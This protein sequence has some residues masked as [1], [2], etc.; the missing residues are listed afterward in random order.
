MTKSMSHKAG[1]CYRPRLTTTS[2]TVSIEN[3]EGTNPESQP[4]LYI[5]TCRYLLVLRGSA[6][7]EP[8][9]N[10]VNIDKSQ[11]SHLAMQMQRILKYSSEIPPC[12]SISFATRVTIPQAFAPGSGCA[13]VHMPPVCT[14]R[15]AKMVSPSD[16]EYTCPPARQHPRFLRGTPASTDIVGIDP[17]WTADG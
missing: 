2:L 10:P 5:S 17:P 6:H 3:W 11:S 12:R 13:S 7:Q 15:P 1:R 9:V 4:K 14:L 16:L 8:L